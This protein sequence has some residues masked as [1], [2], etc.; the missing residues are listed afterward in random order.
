VRKIA[1]A[2]LLLLL[3]GCGS[4]HTGVVPWV[5]RPLPR[6]HVPDAV[7]QRYPTSAPPCRAS[8]LHVTQGRSGAGLGNDLEELVFRNLGARP[9][10]LR[11]YPTIE[12]AGR[13]LR[14]QRGGTYFGQLVPA[15]LAP[16]GRV[17]LDLATGVNCDNGLRRATVYRSLVFT[18]PGGGRVAAPGVAIREVCGLSISEFG[19]QERWVQPAAKPGSAG[20]LLVSMRVPSRAH[21][22]ALFRYTVILRNPTKRTVELRPCPG[23][24]Q[25]LF[26]TRGSVER[27]YALNCD[28]VH[29][30]PPG[31]RVRYAMQVHVPSTAPASYAKLGWNLDTPTGPFTGAAVQVMP[32]RAR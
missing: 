11:G 28:T 9:C 7:L 20:T 18:L 16:H 1:A 6:Y 5:N 4:S 31:G 17:F 22:G 24:T 23:Y 27:S 32:V 13:E 14:P 19:R 2:A 29:A 3:S 10:L 21:A 12:S 25:G 15:D 8:R 30:I 26:T